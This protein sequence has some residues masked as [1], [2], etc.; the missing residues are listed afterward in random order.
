LFF[1]E[2]VLH[3]RVQDG[4]RRRR[5]SARAICNSGA[6]AGTSGVTVDSA[7]HHARAAYKEQRH[8]SFVWRHATDAQCRTE[9][10]IGA[11]LTVFLMR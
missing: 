8:A 10:S 4:N 5:C 3:R 6:Q 1:V 7:G 9:N 11:Q 2:H